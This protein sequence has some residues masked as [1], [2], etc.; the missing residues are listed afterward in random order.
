MD[1]ICLPDFDASAIA[2]LAEHDLG[3]GLQRERLLYALVMLVEW[4]ES[5]TSRIRSARQQQTAPSAER[6]A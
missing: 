2:L 6:V 5:A 1:A 4:R 3:A